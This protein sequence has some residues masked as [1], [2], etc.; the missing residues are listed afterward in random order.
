MPLLLFQVGSV[1]IPNWIPG[2]LLL[3]GLVILASVIKARR[4]QLRAREANRRIEERQA[5]RV[6]KSAEQRRLREAEEAAAEAAHNPGH[7]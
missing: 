4:D 7:E 5:A 3:I 1:E 6:A 2:T